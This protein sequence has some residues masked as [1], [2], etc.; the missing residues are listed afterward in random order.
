M[1]FS[2]FKKDF[3]HEHKIVDPTPP[4][5]FPHEFSPE[6]L[7][8]MA[9]AAGRIASETTSALSRARHEAIVIDEETGKVSRIIL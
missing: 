9:K 1:K 4:G 2:E 7:S 6:T 3:L 8:A 5:A